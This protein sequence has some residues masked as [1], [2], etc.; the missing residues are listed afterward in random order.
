MDTEKVD[1]IIQYALAVAAC[2]DDYQRRELGP[3]H[4]LKYVY[5]AD[6]AWAERNG[7]KTYTGTSWKFYKFGPWAQEVHSRIEPACLFI[8][9]N[10][11]VFNYNDDEEGIRW[12]TSSRICDSLENDLS[13]TVAKA[14]KRAVHEFGSDTSS[15]LN[16]VYLTKPMLNAAPGEILDFSSA[17][18]PQ[19]PEKEPEKETMSFKKQKQRAAELTDARTRIQKKL[20]EKKAAVCRSHYIRKP[21]YDDVYLA[22]Q[23]WLD[24]LAGPQL[25]GIKGEVAF[26]PDIWKSTSR[27]D[28][29]IH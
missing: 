26:S 17:V 5:I 24:S 15:L 16:Y 22:G 20:A 18:L 10:K 9:A 1:K 14:V 7:G 13:I 21:R 3:I 6:I 12:K 28:P 11:R 8:D 4:L 25:P 2:E 23:E 29:E 27:F 19:L